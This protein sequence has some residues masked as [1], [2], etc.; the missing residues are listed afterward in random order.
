M[1][2]PRRFSQPLAAT[3]TQRTRALHPA[4]PALRS[5]EPLREPRTLPGRSQ[6]PTRTSVAHAPPTG[7][8]TPNHASNNQD[9]NG[10]STPRHSSQEPKP[11]PP[12]NLAPPPNPRFAN[13]SPP[14]TPSN[15]AN[16]SPTPH[17]P[18]LR[19]RGP[20]PRARFENPLPPQTNPFCNPVLGVSTGKQHDPMLKRNSVEVPSRA[21]PFA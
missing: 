12:L 4:S 7:Q 11:K 13:P 9:P 18:T 21:C 14:A 10:G 17:P 2:P 19:M 3:P 20:L 15:L 8:W 1:S 16:P 5:P 6:Q